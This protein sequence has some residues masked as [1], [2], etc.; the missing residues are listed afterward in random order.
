MLSFGAMIFAQSTIVTIDRD[1][2]ASPTATGNAAN[3]SSIGLTIGSGVAK[4]DNSI[5]FTTKNW[6]ATTQAEAASNDEYVQWSITANVNFNI[7]ISEYDIRVSRNNNGPANWQ[8]FYSLDGFTTPGIAVA[9][10][11]DLVSTAATDFN[12]NGLTTVNSGSGGTMTFRLY[13]WGANNANGWIRIAAQTAWSDFG[14]TSPGIR[15]MG[16][17]INEFPGKSSES[18]IISSLS[19]NPSENI[20][21]LDWDV[22]SGLTIG[23]SVKIGEFTI[24]D[25]GDDLTDTD[26]F[27]TILTDLGFDVA[28]SS[29]FAALALIDGVTNVSEVTVVNDAIVFNS[30]NS[31]NGITALDNSIKTFF[32]HATF[33]NTV[34]DN[35]QIQLTINSAI[36]DGINGSTFIT[37]DAGGAQ[38]SV[39]GDANRI[40]VNASKLMFSQQPSDVNLLEVMT[41]AVIVQG[42]DVNNNL[43]LDYNGQILMISSIP[44]D[45]SATNI[46]SVVA[47]EAVFDNLVFTLEGTN[48]LTANAFDG[49]SSGASDT[50]EVTGPLFVI[51]VQDFD[52]PSPEWTFTNDIPFFDNGWGVGG[53]YG[54]ID[55][56]GG[57]ATPLDNS[58]FENFI[59][60]ENDLKN[61]SGNGTSQWA[62]LTFAEVDISSFNGVQVRFDWQIIG[63]DSVTDDAEYRLILDGVAQTEVPLFDSSFANPDGIGSESIAI[64]DA[65]NTVSLEVRVRNNGIT[66]FSGFDN[67]RVVS[68]FDGFVYT[69]NNWTPE[70]PSD[71]TGA[72]DALILDGTYTVGSDIALNNVLVANGAEISVLQGQSLTVNS[73]LVNLGSVELNSISQSYSSLIVEGNIIGNVKYNRHVNINAS[74]G[75]N[76][77]ISAPVTGE[78]FSVFAANNTNLFENPG[79]PTEKLFGPFDKTTDTYLTYDTAIPAEA[80][81]ILAPGIGYRAASSNNSTFSFEGVVNTGNITVNIVDSGPISPEWNLIGNP[82]PSYINGLDFLTLNETQFDPLS[83]GVY[84]YDGDASDGYTILNFSTPP[85]EALITPG[86][87]FL[88]ASVPGGGAMA[89]TP[90]MRTNGDTDDFIIG[91]PNSITNEISNAHVK[92]NINSSTDEASYFTDFYFTNNATLGLDPG[93]DAGSFGGAAAKFSIYSHLVEDNTGRDIAVQSMAFT[94]LDSE[95]IIPLGINVLSGQKI[96]V[97]ISESTLPADVDL[98]LEDVITNTFTKLNTNNYLF[99]ADSDISTTGRFFLRFSRTALSAATAELNDLE[100]F[101]TR[102]PKSLF[103][104]GLLKENSNL[105]LYDIRGRLV[106]EVNLNRSILSNEIDLEGLETGVYIVK[107]KDISAI[108]TKKVIIR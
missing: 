60:G 72:E 80:N 87:G 20:N 17:V 63:Y 16:D 104:N 71:A 21:Y 85:E 45:A 97:S 13:A 51:A 76:D 53:Y 38:T 11:T 48:T 91:A 29:Y 108:V 55:S 37:S 12:F 83:F 84:G 8:V 65:V 19:F 32:V 78:T 59:F 100:I 70:A 41:P 35:E 33:K 54:P 24:Q 99:I 23:N 2:N 15:M 81:V 30:I 64:D 88:V 89:F 77:L 61:T 43:D 102:T 75:G 90:S 58:S 98:Y 57:S 67:F 86:Q 66:G 106:K 94:D 103:V 39:A 105:Y 44:L 56:S 74:S 7:D 107:L 34:V 31:G 95:V 82:Y 93:Y 52:S 49:F 3:M 10:A 46:E 18:N 14:I 40:E 22:T 47:G 50:F 68:S 9:A 4:R 36:P 62:T 101:T 79:N 28:N 73:D 42:V 25:G 96:T 5:D 1:N 69:N 6:D 26:L 27:P 92:L